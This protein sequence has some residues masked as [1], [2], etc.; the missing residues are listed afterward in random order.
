MLKNG[1]EYYGIGE[2]PRGGE[3]EIERG[4]SGGDKRTRGKSWEQIQANQP[5]Q[6]SIDHNLHWT[7]ALLPQPKLRRETPATL[8]EHHHPTSQ[9]E[10]LFVRKKGVVRFTPHHSPCTGPEESVPVESPF[11]HDSRKP[12]PI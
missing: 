9:R 10:N 12:S 4:E 2:R 8:Q 1:G 11:F 3:S 7:T 5:I 6:I